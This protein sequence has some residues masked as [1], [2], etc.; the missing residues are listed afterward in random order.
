MTGYEYLALTAD[1]REEL[2][3]QLKPY[4][5]QLYDKI[6]AAEALYNEEFTGPVRNADAARRLGGRNGDLLLSYVYK[7]HEQDCERRLEQRVEQANLE[8]EASIK[9]FMEEFERKVADRIQCSSK[10]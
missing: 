1:L 4:Q 7:W 3:Q 10:A 6:L 8:Y 5:E 2:D 9:P